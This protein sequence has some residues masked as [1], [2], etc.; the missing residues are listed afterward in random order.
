MDGRVLQPTPRLIVMT[1]PFTGLCT[2][3]SVSG[4]KPVSGAVCR[5][6]GQGSEL[7]SLATEGCAASA[8]CMRP[9]VGGSLVLLSVTCSRTSGNVSSVVRP[10]PQRVNGG[11]EAIH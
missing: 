1:T 8:L 2:N 11:P 5:S 10:E 3:L 7:D 4:T 6:L 9:P